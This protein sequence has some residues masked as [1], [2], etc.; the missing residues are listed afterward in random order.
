M[1]VGSHCALVP[2]NDG[3]EEHRTEDATDLSTLEHRMRQKY[4]NDLVRVKGKLFASQHALLA[5]DI[6]SNTENSS[7]ALETDTLAI[8]A[9][10]ANNNKSGNMNAHSETETATINKSSI[11]KTSAKAIGATIATECE[12]K[13]STTGNSLDIVTLKVYVKLGDDEECNTK[14]FNA[15]EEGK[16]TQRAMEKSSRNNKPKKKGRKKRFNR[17]RKQA[18]HGKSSANKHSR[19]KHTHEHQR[20]S[21]K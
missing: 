15:A 16:T 21:D 7:E 17:H 6:D 12:V 4:Y 8:S 13:D 11:E 9:K 14:P 3:D 2:Q 1:F 18:N 10:T 5:D 20:Q 19:R